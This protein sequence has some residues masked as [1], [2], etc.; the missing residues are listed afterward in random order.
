MTTESPELRE[1]DIVSELQY[2]H[3]RERRSLDT[4][5]FGRSAL[6]EVQAEV[7]GATRRF[8]V[9]A[10]RCELDLRRALVPREGAP[11]LALVDYPAGRLP[12][13]L[14]GRLATGA[15]KNV[16][17]ESRL[18]RRFGG[19]SLHPDVQRQRALCD[20]LLEDG[21]PVALPAGAAQLDLDTAWRVLL[22]ARA[23]FPSDGPA[24]LSRLLSHASTAS[25]PSSWL[26]LGTAHPELRAALS[27]WLA[28]AIDPAAPALW[29][30]WEQGFGEP[31]A[32]LTLLL[33]PVAPR[34]GSSAYLRL[35]ARVWLARVSPSLADAI[36]ADVGALSRWGEAE[37]PL[38]R[39]LEQE[40]PRVVTALVRAADDLVHPDAGEAEVRSAVAPST[41]LGLAWTLAQDAFG[42]SLSACLATP[43]KEAFERSRELLRAVE[44][45]R[46]AATHPDVVERAQM[47]LRLLGWRAQ[48][49]DLAY[50]RTDGAPWEVAIRLAQDYVAQGG[51]A[52]LCRRCVRGAS[53][54]TLGRALTD[55][56]EE[57]DRLRDEDDRAFA[58]GLRA[59]SGGGRRSEQ[60]VPIERALEVF[61]ADFLRD[62]PH[63]KLL[64]ILLD[65]AAWANVV[66][67]LTD[68]ETRG[69][70]LLRWRP[71]RALAGAAAPPVLAALPTVT[72][73]SR[74]A[75]FAGK[76]PEAGDTRP[77]SADPTRFA[78]NTALR[79]VADGAKLLLAPELQTAAGGA[80]PE[81]LRL[82]RGDGRVVG[83]VVNAIDDQLHGSRQVRVRY[84]LDAIK[85]L[86][87]LLR[88]ATEAG[89]AVLFAADHG[90][91]PGAR[92][93]SVGARG[94]GHEARWRVLREGESPSAAEAVFQGDGV[95]SPRAGQRVAL[96]TQETDVWGIASGDGAH[97][98]ATLAEVVAPAVM[99]VGTN[100]ARS[101]LEAEQDAGLEAQPLPR[102][103][104]WE[105]E[106][107]APAKRPVES[108]PP[109]E[110]PRQPALPTM[111]IEPPRPVVAAPVPAPVASRW[112][113][114]LLGSAAYVELP[115]P[116]KERLRSQVV[117]LVDALMERE[118]RMD[119]G[120]LE[121][122]LKLLP[123]RGEGVV[124]VVSEIL[125]LEGY[126]V[127]TFDP[128]TRLVTLD[129]TQLSLLHGEESHR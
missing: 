125:N 39:R 5:L 40:A 103:R 25:P 59:W 47:G 122:A 108:S 43:S 111:V 93:R 78:A 28:R 124:S 46:Q 126:P 99:V 81:S 116:Q 38:L 80:S 104:W 83:V 109:R 19:V 77:T 3:R 42:A 62:G 86:A 55:V 129:A 105:L 44:R 36:G 74:A 53:E 91:V 102:P 72:Q 2:I 6:S 92:L 64:V 51:F 128:A 67:L 33:G 37:A 118:G 34:L 79:K 58:E 60:A 69:Y 7:L 27:G 107:S 113:K 70:G 11:L 114:L 50:L 21:A 115:T 117:P 94:E 32:A 85:P 4:A 41:V 52:D 56:E 76:V 45:H 68:L 89:R 30:A 54:G 73:V 66:E 82:V 65:G 71:K 9:V 18:R 63:R 84:T 20:A 1:Q 110:P 26:A 10:V 123:G 100:L 29:N 98:G 12:A 17:T 88:A 75:F 101:T 24:T 112:S 106:W 90:H 120:A 57:A 48:R 13:D 119:I 96:R 16:S 61:G 97:G 121:R 95:W 49:P 22:H 23:G 15:V 127:L 8:R 14:A 87:D 31:I 35:Q